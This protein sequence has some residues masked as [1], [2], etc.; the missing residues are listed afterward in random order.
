MSAEE[1]C[2]LADRLYATWNQSG[3]EAVTREFYDPEIVFIDDPSFPG[4]GVV[5]GRDRVSAHLVSFMEGLGDFKITVLEALPFP[6]GALA[7]VRINSTGPAS[8][9]PI[10]TVLYHVGRLRSGRFVEVRTFRQRSEALA[11]AGLAPT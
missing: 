1:A 3:A 4:A 6:G 2:A 10:E 8:G 7:G 9:A 11:A 5:R